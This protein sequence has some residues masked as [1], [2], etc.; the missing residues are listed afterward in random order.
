MTLRFIP[1]ARRLGLCVALAGATAAS[2]QALP[3][4]RAVPQPSAPAALSSAG[5]TAAPPITLGPSPSGLRS[6]FPAG[7]PTPVPAGSDTTNTVVDG[8]LVDAV[9]ATQVMG[10]AAG[11]YTRSAPQYVAS[12]PGPYTALEVARS[13]LTADA[14][15]DG[16]LTRAEATRLTLMPFAFEEM[17]RD[18]NGVLTKSEYEDALR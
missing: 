9:P 1:F 17:D 10:A 18:H 16:D 5:T 11:G 12:G 14:N 8:V 6:P 7:L 4:V 2:A 13:F 3:G 15:R